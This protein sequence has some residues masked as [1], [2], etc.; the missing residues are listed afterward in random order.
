MYEIKPKESCPVNPMIFKRV[1]EEIIPVWLVVLF[2]YILSLVV[3]LQ[4]I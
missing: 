1:I 4:F 3:T 2:Q